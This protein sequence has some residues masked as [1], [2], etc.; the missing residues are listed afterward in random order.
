MF[1]KKPSQ[2]ERIWAG[3]EAVAVVQALSSLPLQ[4]ADRGDGMSIHGW[5]SQFP[6]ILAYVCMATLAPT[7][8]KVSPLVPRVP[9]AAAAAGMNHVPG[10]PPGGPAAAPAVRCGAVAPLSVGQQQR[11]RGMRVPRHHTGRDTADEPHVLYWLS[12]TLVHPSWVVP[13]QPAGSRE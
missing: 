9:P 12:W 6:C 1:A 3:K 2:E 13:A 7:Q 5:P 11:H 10:S 4:P 8:L